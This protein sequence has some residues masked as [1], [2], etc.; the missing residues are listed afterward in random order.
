MAGPARAE[1]AR[2]PRAGTLQPLETNSPASLSPNPIIGQMIGQVQSSILYGY[3]AGLSGEQPVSV[4][5]ASVT[6]TTRS[7]SSAAAIAQATQYAFEHFA[8]LGLPVAYHTWSFNGG[9]RRNVVATQA[10]A[11]PGCLYLLAAHIDDASETP[12]TLAPGA[13]DNASGV[14]GVFA[15][16]EILSRY[17]FACSLQ[18][19]IFSGEEQGLLGSEA[20]AR[21]AALRGDPILGVINLDM[22][23][24]NTAGSAAT[25]E[26]DIRSGPEGVKDQALSTMITGV[27]QAYQLNLIPLVYASNDDGSDQYSFWVSGFPALLMIEDWD[28]HTPHYHKTTDRISTLDFAYFAEMTKAVVGAAA[29][30]A[31]P[32]HEVFLPFL[33]R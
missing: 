8:A 14:A 19:V 25:M 2:P 24:F 15:A 5:G 11:N 32:A 6:L 21:D 17:R 20:Y 1:A 4:G 27:I 16:A 12:G 13:D 7:T 22:I 23:A 9:V 28:N 18:Y 31:R 29:H 33:R 30:L 10:G 26:M 3:V